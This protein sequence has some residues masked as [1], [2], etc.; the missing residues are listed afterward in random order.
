MNLVL[1]VAQQEDLT[2]TKEELGVR[3]M[4]AGVMPQAKGCPTCGAY[5]GRRRVES[6]LDEL[7]P[8]R[9]GALLKGIYHAIK[10]NTNVASRGGS[11]A[12][13]EGAQ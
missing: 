12:E 10:C 9:M 5:N 13:K 8:E 11:Q 3:F 2:I 1:E 6:L 4:L 7:L